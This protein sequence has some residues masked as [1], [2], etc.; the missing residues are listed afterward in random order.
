MKTETQTKH[1]PSPWSIVENSLKDSRVICGNTGTKE[2]P[3][4]SI[5]ASVERS[6][7]GMAVGEGFANATLM[8]AAP[9]LLAACKLAFE[10]PTLSGDYVKEKLK[11]AITKAEGGAK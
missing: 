1:T 2:K 11:D 3:Y 8:V 4:K 7:G 5:I 10:Y 9:E 6:Y